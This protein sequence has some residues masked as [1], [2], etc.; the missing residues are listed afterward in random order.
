VLREIWKKMNLSKNCNSIR[1]SFPD[2]IG[3]SSFFNRFW[4]VQSSWT[5]TNTDFLTSPNSLFL[6]EQMARKWII[7]MQAG[8]FLYRRFLNLKARSYED[9]KMRS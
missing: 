2:L 3:E 8:Y 9:K 7:N 4:I 1:L 5:M 6:G